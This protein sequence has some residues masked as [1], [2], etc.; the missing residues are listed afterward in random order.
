MDGSTVAPT[1]VE[2]SGATT[3]IVGMGWDAAD[4]NIQIMHNDLS[5]VA[6]KIDL[7]ANF[8]VP[9]VD[10]G[11]VY[12]LQLYSPN[13]A[14]QSVRYRVTRFN[15]NLKTPAFVAEGVITTNLPP[16]AT[17][18]GPVCRM[19]VGGTSSVIG[20]SIMGILGVREY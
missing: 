13:D 15:A 1:D 20:V 16:V 4:T 17:M 8:P 6:T 11:E 5:G 7:G 9:T 2:P 18:L 19:S 14:V 10:R 12:E 3:G